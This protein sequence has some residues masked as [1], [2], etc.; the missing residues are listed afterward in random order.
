[1]PGGTE[2]GAQFDIFDGRTTVPL[3]IEAAK[4][5]E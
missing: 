5:E 3:R 2:P 4:G 1:M